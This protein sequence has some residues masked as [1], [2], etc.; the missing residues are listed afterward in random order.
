MPGWASSIS[1]F[2]DIDLQGVNVLKGEELSK[3]QS[4]VAVKR[5][6]SRIHNR[7]HPFR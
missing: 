6:L 2:Q 5:G 4:S 1:F 7:H 3:A